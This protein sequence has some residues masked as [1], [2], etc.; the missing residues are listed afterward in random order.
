[1]EIKMKKPYLLGLDIGTS[2]CTVAVFDREGSV[3]RAGTG[4]YAVYYPHPGWAEQDPD[5]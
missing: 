2:A 1:M 5:E 4:E 3:V